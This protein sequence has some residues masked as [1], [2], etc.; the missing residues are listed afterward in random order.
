MELRSAFSI[1]SRDRAPAWCPLPP[2]AR[3][4]RPRA[5]LQGPRADRRHVEALVLLRLR[6]FTTT[7]PGQSAAARDAGVRPST[8]DRQDD[9]GLTTTV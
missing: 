2:P 9:A 8:L 1:S 7:A 5:A 6:A 4:I 3:C